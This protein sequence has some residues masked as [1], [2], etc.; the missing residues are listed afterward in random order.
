MKKIDNFIKALPDSRYKNIGPFIAPLVMLYYLV[1]LIPY[2]IFYNNQKN[3]GIKSLKR[4][5]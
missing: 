2:I 5:G 3:N 4:T 1:T